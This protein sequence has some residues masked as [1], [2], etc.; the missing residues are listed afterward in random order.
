MPHAT[1]SAIARRD[2]EASGRFLDDLGEW[3]STLD[4]IAGE[5]EALLKTI[6]E[7]ELLVSTTLFAE[8][9]E[10]VWGAIR[11]DPDMYQ[12]GIYRGLDNSY[13]WCFCPNQSNSN[14]N[15]VLAE[16]RLDGDGFVFYNEILRQQCIYQLADPRCFERLLDH[17]WFDFDCKLS[18]AQCR[19]EWIIQQQEMSSEFDGYGDIESRLHVLKSKR[20]L[21]AQRYKAIEHD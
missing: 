13:D 18:E 12:I 6:F 15:V 21:F 7:P 5:F 8:N 19:M 16:I 17:V 1:Q 10:T 9:T 14:P 3:V 20:P 2:E 11:T 4:I